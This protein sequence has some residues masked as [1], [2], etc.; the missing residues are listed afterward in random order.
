MPAA[1]P[2]S[3]QPRK[4]YPNV[5][6]FGGTRAVFNEY[7]ET[8]INLSKGLVIGSGDTRWLIE[9]DANNKLSVA[10]SSNSG[11]TYALKMRISPE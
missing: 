9:V 8:G 4:L 1:I 11:Q 10:Y 6:G 5:G 7:D 3:Y 2:I